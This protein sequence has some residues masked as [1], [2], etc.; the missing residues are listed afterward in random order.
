MNEPVCHARGASTRAR[1]GGREPLHVRP[2]RCWRRCN[3]EGGGAMPPSA[4]TALGSICGSA[5]AFERGRLAN[6]NPPQAE[7]LR[8][9]GAPAAT[10]SSS[11][12]PITRSWTISVAEGLHCSAWDA[13]GH[14]GRDAGPGANVARS[15]RLLHGVA[16]GGRPPVPH[17]HDQ[18]RG[19]GPAAATRHRRGLAAEDPAARLRPSASSR[20]PPSAASPSAWA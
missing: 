6:E 12:R 4:L 15:G 3:R 1:L 20:R 18:R 8:R 2:R 17:H 9:Q 11:T 19:A 14:A 7:D 13:S 10:S 16:D 5:E